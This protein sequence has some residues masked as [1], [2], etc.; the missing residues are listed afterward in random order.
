MEDYTTQYRSLQYD[1]SMHSSQYDPLFFA[2][3][4]VRGLRDDICA[5][6]ESQAPTTVEKASVIA[7]IQQKV[8]D[9][10][11]LKYQGKAIQNRGI[12]LNKSLNP[13]L[14]L[15]ICGE[16]NSSETIERHITCAI[17]M[18]RNMT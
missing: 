14:H 10:Q 5:V 7:R 9:R 16:T 17:I 12:P 18:E 15:A 8:V 11:R 1:V 4:Y 3:Q 6:V 2:T 13:P